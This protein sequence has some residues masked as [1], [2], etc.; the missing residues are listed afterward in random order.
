MKLQQ[1]LGVVFVQTVM[2]LPTE[3]NSLTSN[4]L[5]QMSRPKVFFIAAIV[6]YNAL[7]EGFQSPN[8]NSTA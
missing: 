1:W 4:S 2:I 7:L 5:S 3:I 8:T 6:F